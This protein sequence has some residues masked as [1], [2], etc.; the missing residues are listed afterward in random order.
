[1]TIVKQKNYI[2]TKSLW[3]IFPWTDLCL[4]YTWSIII[5]ALTIW[6]IHT[7]LRYFDVLYLYV[8]KIRHF[9]ISGLVK[10][11]PNREYY[12]DILMNM[13]ISM[14]HC[15]AIFLVAIFFVEQICTNPHQHH[16]SPTPPHTSIIPHRRHPA[17][18]SP[19]TGV[20][21]HWR[22]PTLALPCNWITL[23]WRH[24]ALASPCTGVTP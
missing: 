16:P 8:W 23:H 14:K 11:P 1:M 9:K 7:H 10:T 20:N 19:L 15:F 12:F 4:H 21:P 6:F 24:P 2:L 13:I 3:L 18:V 5:H 22:Y 17:M